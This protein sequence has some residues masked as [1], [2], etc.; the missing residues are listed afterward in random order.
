MVLDEVS[1]KRVEFPRL[2]TQALVATLL[3][4]YHLQYALNQLS[5]AQLHYIVRHAVHRLGHHASRVEQPVNKHC[6][7]T[8]QLV[9]THPSSVICE[10]YSLHATAYS[11]PRAQTGIS[12]DLLRSM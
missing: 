5:L 9:V 4:H 11:V 12:T 1:T 7:P 8:L 2:E 6:P 3:L 10:S